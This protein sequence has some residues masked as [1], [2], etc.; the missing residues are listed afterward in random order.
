MTA[1]GRGPVGVLVAMVVCAVCAVC[2]GPAAGRAPRAPAP[3]APRVQAPSAILVEPATGDI[4]FQRRPGARRAIASTTKLMTALLVLE[5]TTLNDRLTVVPYAAAPVESVAG[6][7]AGERLTVAD[8]L[9]ALLLASANDAAVTLATRVAGTREAFVGL[10]NRRARQL[11]L[12]DTH[13]AN[14]VGLDD[15]RNHSSARDLVKLTL[16]LWRQAFFRQTVDRPQA[17]LHSGARQRTVV[18]RNALVRSTPFVTGVKTGHT[19]SAG[20]VLVGSATRRGVTLVSAVLGDPS[21]A[22]RNRD[23]LALLR[24]G[25]RTYRSTRPVRR[26]QALGR[27]PLRYRDGAVPLVASAAVH[28]TVRRGERLS[29]RVVDVPESLEGPLPRGSRAGTVLVGQRGRTVARV[30]L[31]TAADVAQTTV[32]ERLRNYLSRPVSLVLVGVLLLCS[33]LLFVLRRRIEGGNRRRARGRETGGQ[34]T[35]TKIA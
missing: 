3:P 23:T 10:M 35:G 1:A 25:L 20:Y 17:T 4:V 5:R 30:P 18:N 9:R 26:G 33:L 15:P 6:L 19:Q 12:R 27:A 22:A 24:L 31:V 32:T 34:E 13:F 7:R 16:I 14:P 21:E 2:A 11:G 28:R 29:V 8:L